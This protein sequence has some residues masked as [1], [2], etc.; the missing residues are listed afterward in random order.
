[1]QGFYIQLQPGM[2][3]IIHY[4]TKTVRLFQP[5]SWLYPITA[6]LRCWRVTFWCWNFVHNNDM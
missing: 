6:E 2:I 5:I 4:T 3:N 1:M